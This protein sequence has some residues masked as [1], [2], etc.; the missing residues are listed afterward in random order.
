MRVFV[1]LYC[2]EDEVE[3]GGGYRL[4]FG[5]WVLLGGGTDRGEFGGG[6]RGGGG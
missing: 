5:E 6:G 1:I 3:R 2:R 4:V